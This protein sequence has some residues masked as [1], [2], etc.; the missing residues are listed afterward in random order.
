[1]ISLFFVYRTADKYE[2]TSITY[3]H[4]FQITLP[5]DIST[6]IMDFY[7]DYSHQIYNSKTFKDFSILKYQLS[8]S[9][10]SF[11]NKLEAKQGISS[12][13][14]AGALLFTCLVLGIMKM[15]M[16]KNTSKITEEQEDKLQEHKRF[17]ESIINS[18]I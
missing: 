15:R 2:I 14:L 10:G 6:P 5:A 11:L 1:M 16:S 4:V 8:S 17:L 3:E 9:I 18:E 7:S 12:E 13:I